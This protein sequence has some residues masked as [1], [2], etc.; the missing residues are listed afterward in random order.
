MRVST[1]RPRR[2][3]RVT[4]L[5]L[6]AAIVVGGGSAGA[7]WWHE[8]VAVERLK[9]SETRLAEARG[10]YSVLADERRQW[11]HFSSR[12][13]E[14]KARGRIGPEQPA[15][16]SDA[17][18]TASSGV[19]SSSHRLGAT[20]PAEHDGAVE[21]RATDMSLELR[22]RHELE[23]PRFLSA[24]E[25]EARGAFTVAGCRLARL[26]SE[27]ARAP[28]FAAIGA[29]CRLRWHNVSVSGLEPVWPLAEAVGGGED[30][31]DGHFAMGGIRGGEPVA[32]LGRLFT[33]PEERARIESAAVAQGAAERGSAGPGIRRLP[34]PPPSHRSRWVEVSGLVAR[35]DRSVAAWIDGKRVEYE[36]RS[37]KRPKSIDPRPPGVPV[38]V[39]GRRIAVL[40]GQRFDPATGVIA[41]PVRREV[42]RLE[43]VHP[44]QESSHLPLTVPPTSGKN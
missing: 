24:L 26:G 23:L 4:L 43:R 34:R 14:W 19:S 38:E 21:V 13:R 28:P 41:D 27:A 20:R 18:R 8:R 16:W 10:N 17:V 42:L 35:A 5:V 7:G 36:G 44:L 3:R 9:W 11:R 31:N 33:T 29:S 12:F 39:G 30:A 25:R 40:P 32:S 6:S 1:D 15:Q 2:R 37:A 22:L